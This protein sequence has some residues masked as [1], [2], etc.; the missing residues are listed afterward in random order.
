[1]N[2]IVIEVIEMI[3]KYISIISLLLILIFSCLGVSISDRDANS[4]IVRQEIYTA[5]GNTLDQPYWLFGLIFASL[6]WMGYL[7]LK[8]KHNIVV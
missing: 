2:I 3:K 5:N 4:F 7:Y 6:S 8:E 1:M